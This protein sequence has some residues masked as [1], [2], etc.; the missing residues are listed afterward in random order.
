VLLNSSCLS[1]RCVSIDVAKNS[2]VVSVLICP[3]LWEGHVAVACSCSASSANQ[4]TAN[5]HTVMP[6]LLQL[7]LSFLFCTTAATH[8]Q[9]QRPP[10][11]SAATV[12]CRNVS[13]VLKLIQLTCQGVN[14]AQ[15]F[16][17]MHQLCGADCGVQ[18]APLHYL[19]IASPQGDHLP[20]RASPR[21]GLPLPLVARLSM[22]LSDLS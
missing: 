19:Q 8:V 12:C 10:F 20:T 15:Q 7:C 9:Q 14:G 21:Q 17:K 13:T 2:A 16:P 4:R 11:P 22:S 3:Q 1:V 18:P 6:P 5:V